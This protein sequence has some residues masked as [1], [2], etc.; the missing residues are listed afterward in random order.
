MRA[1]AANK[2]QMAYTAAAMYGGATVLGVVEQLFPGG[3]SFSV[4]PGIG[5]LALVVLLLAVGPRLPIWTLATLGPIGAALIA[6]AVATTQQP[7]DAAVLYAWPVLWTSFFFGARGAVLIL[8]WLGIVHG[9]AVLSLDGGARTI[10]RWLDVMVSMA[11]VAAVVEA[12]AQRNRDLLDEL[13]HDARTD[14]LTGLL[15]RRGFDE[16]VPHELAR[17]RRDDSCVGVVTFD[18][19]RFKGINDEWGHDVGD[20]VLVALA[21]VFRTESRAGDIVA[22]MGGEEFTAVLAIEDPLDAVEYAERVRA[23]FAAIDAG[24]GPAT[25]SAGIASARRPPSAEALL[26]A[27]D[28]A[29]YEAKVA[30]RDRV[31]VSESP[32]HPAV[33]PAPV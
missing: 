29:L 19:D 10:D 25:I 33:R 31:V 27:A 28:A 20:R 5:A 32:G 8:V 13:V 1:R 18:I 15:N 26:H 22:R 17:S 30:G 4:W 16:L 11:I 6:A 3:Q 9:V 14:Q 21:D 2:R 7:G 24:A 23:A 12:L